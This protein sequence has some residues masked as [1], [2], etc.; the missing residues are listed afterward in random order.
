MTDPLHDRLSLIENPESRLACVILVDVSNSMSGK[1]ITEVNNG[2][3]KLG[4]HIEEDE[5]T[6]MRADIAI[7]AFNHEHQVVR[8]FGEHIDFSHPDL[9]AEGGTKIA[10]PIA[11][12]LDM[13]EHRK[14][15]YREAGIP[16]YRPIV[17]LITDGKP[18]HDTQHDIDAIARRVKEAEQSKSLTFFAIGTES[19]DMATLATLTNLPPKTLRGTN[20]DELFKW[21]SNSI[22]AISNSQMGDDVTLPSTDGWSKY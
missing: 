15:Q 22:A 11:N 7:I 6:S 9:Q 2:I 16:Y 5:L 21:L 18:E 12:A 1:P 14:M 17:M 19:A 13:I 20:F 3:I 8:N 4:Q 10:A